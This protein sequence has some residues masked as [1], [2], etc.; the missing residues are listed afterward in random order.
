MSIIDSQIHIWRAE[1]PDRP[2]VPGSAI[3]AQRAEPLGYE[4]LVGLMD[5]AGVDRAV[6]VPPAWEGDRND[7]A[8][9]AV[10]EFPSRFGV[11]GRLT[12]GQRLSDDELAAWKRQ[13]GMLGV[14]LSFSTPREQDWLRDGVTDW[15]W[16]AAERLGVPVMIRP[17]EWFHG[18]GDIADR[19]RGLT[20]IIDHM[21]LTEPVVAAGRGEAVIQDVL[22]LAHHPNISVKCS[23]V[24]TYSS[25]AYPFRDMHDTI[26]R[27]FDA[28]GP[29]RL[30]WGTDLSRLLKKCSY[31]EAISMFTQ[32]LDFLTATDKS[33]IM[34]DALAACLTWSRA[35]PMEQQP[36]LSHR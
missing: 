4:E 15:F 29:R 17:P 10:A 35:G 24:P 7:F 14:R 5:E 20:I 2:W 32:E 11:M 3:R 27:M 19:H 23:A 31:R 8:L 28:Y 30:F 6:L 18:L 16:A 21:G 26:H 34:G 22:S 13:P 12:L 25:E 33:L 36:R 1:T 9:E